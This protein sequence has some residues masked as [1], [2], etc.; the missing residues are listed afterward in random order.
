MRAGGGGLGTLVVIPWKSVVLVPVAES[1]GSKEGEVPRLTAVSLSSE[2]FQARGG[3][4][5]PLLGDVSSSAEKP[6]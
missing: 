2:K 1:Q 6:Q 3:G 5:G 4:G